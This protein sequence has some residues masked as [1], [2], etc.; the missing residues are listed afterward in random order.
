M[1][2]KAIP[3]WDKVKKTKGCWVWTGSTR[4]TTIKYGAAWFF[5]ARPTSLTASPGF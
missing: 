5:A 4:G 3:F 2:K 1:G